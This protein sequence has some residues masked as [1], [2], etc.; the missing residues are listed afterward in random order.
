MPARIKGAP[1][2]ERRDW[3]LV[4]GGTNLTPKSSMA[5]VKMYIPIAHL[6]AV[7]REMV[8]ASRPCATFARR[9]GMANWDKFRE[10][11][12]F[13]CN[14][15]GER[16]FSPYGSFNG[17]MGLECDGCGL[18]FVQNMPDGEC[19]KAFYASSYYDN[20]YGGQGYEA[21]YNRTLRKYFEYKTRLIA[22]QLPPQGNPRILEIGGGPGYFTKHLLERGYGSVHCWD[23]SDAAVTRA[24]Q[25]GVRVEKVDMFQRDDMAGSFD[26]VVSWATL[27]HSPD[28]TRFFAQLMKL[29]KPQGYIMI[30]TPLIGTFRDRIAHGISGWFYPPEHI[31]LFTR[32]ALVTLTRECSST[33]LVQTPGLPAV[34]RLLLPLRCLLRSLSGKNPNACYDVCLV[35]ARK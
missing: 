6:K 4:Y 31:H 18:V 10:Y 8:D 33:T 12:R 27:E 26:L 19:L 11:D 25:I 23:I 29:A 21:A 17:Y 5:A 16:A 32:K 1:A 34:K 14:V 7:Q 24:R 13:R 30:D 22:D 3:T 9:C 28:P 15:C 2:P 35:M 20:Y